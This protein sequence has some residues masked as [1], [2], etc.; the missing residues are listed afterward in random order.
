MKEKKL[1]V[2]IYGAGAM[3]TILGA[4]IAASG[5]QI[6]LITRNKA[7]V[8]AI[9]E[10]GAHVLGHAN[11]TVH[12]NAYTPDEMTG[13]YDIIFLMTKQRDNPKILATLRDFLANDGVICTMQNGLPEPSVINAVGQR[14]CLGCAV[15]WGAK[16]VGFGEVELSSNQE[17]MTFALGSMHGHDKWIGPVKEYL[18]CAGKVTV[19]ENFFGARWAKLVLNSAF[20]PLSA[21]TGMTFG[22]VAKWKYT[23]DLA[24]AL[25]NE[26]F[27]VAEQCGV[28]IAP[29]QGHDIVALFKCNGGIKAKVAKRLLP[30]AMRGHKDLVSGMYAD[31]K[32][33][34]K[35]E[36]EF[37]NGIIQ[38][39]GKKFDVATPVNDAVIEYIGQIEKGER[40]ISSDNAKQIYNSVFKK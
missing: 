9:K 22:K 16:S 35:C 1:R 26:A 13:V 6:D 30:L 2:A 21:L 25:M 34:K 38:K 28:E 37:I 20:S 29:I 17:K 4:Y 39:L 5:K 8:E 10:H 18:E 11:F 14:R 31:L 36:V 7:H 3:G 40:K 32:A 12:V 24:L 23:R 15:S 27:A 19:E 33:G